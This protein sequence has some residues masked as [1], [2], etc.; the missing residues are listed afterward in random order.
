MVCIFFLK[1]WTKQ[2]KIESQLHEMSDEVLDKHLR[3]FYAEVKNK[4]DEDY[5]KSALVGIKHGIERYLN[6]PPH[7]RCLNISTNP[8][9]KMS[10]GILNAKIVSLKSKESKK[11]RTNLSWKL[12]T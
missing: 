5:S 10:N 3:Q 1:E 2:R 8:V 7:S 9:Y 6:C 4:Q 11:F 12:K